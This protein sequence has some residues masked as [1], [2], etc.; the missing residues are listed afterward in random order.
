[1]VGDLLEESLGFLRASPGVLDFEDIF[2]EVV[3][4]NFD[5]PPVV[6]SVSISY[7]TP[8]SIIKF[9]AGNSRDV[10]MQRSTEINSLAALGAGHQLQVGSDGLSVV[11]FQYP[12][13]LIA[14]PCMNTTATRVY[15]EDMVEAKILSQCGIDNLNA[16]GYELPALVTDV[17]L[18]AA[19]ADVVVVRQV[20]IEA[21]LLRDRLEDRRRPDRPAI[22]GIRRVDRS[23]LD[24]SRHQPQHV[25]A[26]SV[27]KCQPQIKETGAWSA[28]RSEVVY[29]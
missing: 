8:L 27:Q 24:T 5:A 25:F 17:R 10:G 2:L 18:V 1:M 20:N 15:P 3:L 7:T 19:R 21:Q 14:D 22:S 26:K 4:E 28:N 29:D 11:V 12:C 13:P 6:R 9:E 23:N 16:H